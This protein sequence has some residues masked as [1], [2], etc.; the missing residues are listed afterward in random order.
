VTANVQ[1]MASTAGQKCP[2]LPGTHYRSNI[3]FARIPRIPLH[4]VLWA[5]ITWNPMCGTIAGAAMRKASPTK[6][7]SHVNLTW[8][9][10]LHQG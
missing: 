1:E 9:Q 6:L 4:A 7:A 10:L 5:R 8:H 2:V 3:G